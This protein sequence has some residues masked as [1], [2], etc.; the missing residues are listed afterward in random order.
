MLDRESPDTL[1]RKP[2]PGNWSALEALNHIYLSEKLS[3]EYVRY[4]LSRPE[5]IPS[6]RP[7]AWLRTWMLKWILYSPLK[8]KSPP[9]INMWNAQPVL[10][11][12]EL[13]EAW[14]DLRAGLRQVLDEHEI[15]LRNKLTYKQ[16]YAGRMTLNQMLIFFDDHLVHHTRQIR[17]IWGVRKL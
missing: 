4:K 12:P 6:S 13:K 10:S 5:T 17:R 11:L 1:N 7:D 9:Q 16:P 2:G 3:L 8:V 15:P 14:T